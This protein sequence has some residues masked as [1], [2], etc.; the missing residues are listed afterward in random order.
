MT[1]FEFAKVVQAWSLITPPLRPNP[2][3][4]EAIKRSIGRSMGPALLLGVTPEYANLTPNIVAADI[5]INMVK[6]LWGRE[7]G[8]GKAVVGD[9]RRMPFASGSFSLCLG[10]GSFTL[11]HYPD[12]F[13]TL[14]DEI[15]RVLRPQARVACRVFACPELA[16]SRANLRA[17]VMS[18]SVKSFDTLKWRLGMMLGPES[19]GHNVPLRDILDAF[20]TMFPDQDELVR[21]TGWGRDRLAAFEANYASAA[22]FFCF[23]PR[24]KLEAAATAFA[25]IHFVPTG[26]YELAECCPLMVMER[27]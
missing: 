5:S 19:P 12:E 9:W 16:E 26:T 8:S 21:V 13:A 14:F 22:S 6:G 23:A 18:G 7:N 15:A 11:M 24:S 25:G 27:R 17:A 10:D 4:V 1:G 2:E 3:V 20:H